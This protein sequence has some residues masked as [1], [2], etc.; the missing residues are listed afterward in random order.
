MT[1]FPYVAIEGVIG[2]ERKLVADAIV[3]AERFEADSEVEL[4]GRGAGL[5]DSFLR[6]TAEW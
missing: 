4:V 3:A 6:R 2:A 5:H 1:P